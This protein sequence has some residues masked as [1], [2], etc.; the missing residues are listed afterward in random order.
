M[1]YFNIQDHLIVTP[2]GAVPDSSVCLDAVGDHFAKYPER[3][4]AAFEFLSILFPKGQSAE[5]R[6]EV[7][8]RLRRGKMDIADGVFAT[9]SDYHTKPLE[10]ALP[11]SH[12]RYVDIQYVAYGKECIGLTRDAIPVYLPYDSEKDIA[13]YTP[14]NLSYHIA[15]PNKF[16]VFFPSDFHAPGIS[17]SEIFQTDI[18]PITSEFVIK[19]VVKLL[20]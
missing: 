6:N 12:Q 10:Q 17:V 5:Q 16:F 8:K 13:F 19:I 1:M 4:Q 15:D 2:F 14:K 18:V 11:E 7:L 9:I 20:F 3:W